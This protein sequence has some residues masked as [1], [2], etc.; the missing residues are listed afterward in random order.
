MSRCKACGHEYRKGALAFL[1]T[2]QG[3]KGA[4]VCQACASGGALLVAP[5]VAPVMKRAVDRG[6]VI[7]R[8][9]RHLRT[10]EG[11]ARATYRQHAAYSQD[12]G[13]S[14]LERQQHTEL[15]MMADGRAQ[16]FEGA[17]EA[18]KREC[19]P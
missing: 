17:I 2:A 1:L 11:A 10:L 12:E 9:L 13:K 15:A 19:A 6:D 14:E 16:G 7:E 3:L 4:R 5:K 8:A 18:I